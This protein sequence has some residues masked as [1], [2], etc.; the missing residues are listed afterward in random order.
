MDTSER[1]TF[2]ITLIITCGLSPTILTPTICFVSFW[3][4][5][6]L[7]SKLCL[8]F[9][10]S[11]DYSPPGSSVHGIPQARILERVA[12]S[13]SGGLLDPGTKPASLVSPALQVGSWLLSHQGSPLKPLSLSNIPCNLPIII[14]IFSHLSQRI[15]T[16][17][18]WCWRRLLRVSW[19]GRRSSQSILKEINLDYPLEGL[20][21]KLQH[22]GH[23]MHWLI[24]KDPDA[25][26]DWRQE[27]KG[28][29][30]DEMVE[31]HYW[32]NGYEF[33]QTRGYCEGQGSLACRSPWG[34]KEPDMT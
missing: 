29:I 20:M 17:E 26:K 8:T 7:F 5:L 6:F 30:E 22:F 27:E 2:H 34:F 24:R 19:T 25:G 4:P 10:N 16:F 33:E 13:F 18:L 28:M 12:I 31:W 3:S 1:L 21:L 11:I 15:D 23:L 9:C 14:F 32:L